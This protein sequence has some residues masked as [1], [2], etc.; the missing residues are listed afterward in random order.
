MKSIY[1]FHVHYISVE[2]FH[3]V[4]IGCTSI[5]T[6]KNET[7]AFDCLVCFN[8]CQYC[9]TLCPKLLP[10]N[11]ALKHKLLSINNALKQGI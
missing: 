9:I 2:I 4:V 6:E 7:I 8:T 1:L 10:I 5:T 3:E 11:N